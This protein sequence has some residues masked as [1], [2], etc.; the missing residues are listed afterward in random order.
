MI[1]S[2]NA[3]MSKFS[4]D[5]YCKIF[6]N[7]VKNNHR[8][9]L[10]ITGEGSKQQISTVHE[11]LS[12]ISPLNNVIWCYKNME[13]SIDREAKKMKP[14]DEDDSHTKWIKTINV[15]YIPYNENNRILGKTCDMLILQD[16]EAVTPNIIACTMETVRGGGV[17]VLLFDREKSIKEI[18]SCESDIVLKNVGQKFTP[19]FN[20][21]LFKSLT[22]QNFSIFLDSKLRV[23]DVTKENH[24]SHPVEKIEIDTVENPVL[25]MCKTKDQFNVL[26]SLISSIDMNDQS[27]TSVIA[28]RGRGKSVAL[29]LAISHALDKNTPF[30]LV[31]SLFLDN[32]QSIFEFVINGLDKL[33]YKKMADYKI[34]YKFEGKKRLINRIEVTRNYKR[35]VEFVHSFDD[36]KMYP[37]LL[38]IDEAASIPLP[39]LKKLLESRFVFMASTVNGYEG[40]GRVFKTKLVEY[41]RDKSIKHTFLEMSEP[42]RYSPG[43]P[44]EKWLNNSLLLIPTIHPIQ[45]CSLP[46]ECSIFHVNKSVLFSGHHKSEEFLN[47]IFSL[48]ISSHYRNSPNDLQIL[49]DSPNHEIFVQ[50][51]PTRPSRVICAIQVSFEG[52]CN[53]NSFTKEGNLIPWVVYDNFFDDSFLDLFGARIVRIATHPNLISMGY[54]SKAL[55]DLTVFLES[56][57][58]DTGCTSEEDNVLLHP[59]KNFKAPKINWIGSS[60]GLTEKLLNFWKKSGFSPVCIKQTPSK[61]TGEYSCLVLKMNEAGYTDFWSLFLHRFIPLLSFSFKDFTPTLALSLIYSSEC[62]IPDKVFQF[63]DDEMKRLKMFSEGMLDVRSIIDILPDIS[64]KFFY[65]KDLNKLSV[66]SQSILIMIGCQRKTVE[67]VSKYFGIEEFKIKNILINTILLFI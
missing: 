63:T 17:I 64:K 16:F 37:S 11:K 53:K 14:S 55:S 47:E 29:G 1:Y 41:I 4:A 10:I 50:M 28:S 35:C 6:A 44:V 38:V 18:I 60:F 32:V 51:T 5:Y 3:P 59:L 61:T 30:I 24:E 36:L 42:I 20:R 2:H 45:S 31:S 23:M 40:T 56:S 12:K 65:Q 13:T 58:D 52:K 33:G 49:S 66:V 48:F 57:G 9:M 22:Q 27:V 46:S 21:R 54:G 39:Y 19:R 15:D 34:E 43:D 8:T 25:G 62:K 7:Q 26:S 67:D